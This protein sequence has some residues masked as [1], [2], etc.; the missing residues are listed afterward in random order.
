MTNEQLDN[1]SLQLNKLLY[2][3][4]DKKYLEDAIWICTLLDYQLCLIEGQ[5]ETWGID[6]EKIIKEHEDESWNEIEQILKIN[7]D[8]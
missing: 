4:D 6:I 1:I 2:V 7:N 8:N 5:Y 3:C